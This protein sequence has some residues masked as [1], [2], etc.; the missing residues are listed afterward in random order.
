MAPGSNIQT[1]ALDSGGGVVVRP[2]G[3]VDMSRSPDLRQALRSALDQRPSLCVVDL[4]DVT[5]MDSSGLATLVEAMRTAKSA[6]SD[7]VLA[8]MTPKVK[9]I[10]EMARLDQF[11]TIVESVDEATG[12]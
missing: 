12:R 3:D 1:Q 11:F 9:A 10:F 5:Y 2:E 6:K 8:A 4:S 7:L